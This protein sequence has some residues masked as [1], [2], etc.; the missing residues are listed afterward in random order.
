LFS[1]EVLQP[2]TVPKDVECIDKAQR[3]F[4]QEKC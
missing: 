3:S 2:H 4:W 1:S